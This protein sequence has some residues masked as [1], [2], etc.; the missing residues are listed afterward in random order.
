M[1][2]Q[3]L[4]LLVELY[5]PYILPMR[6][7]GK[8]PPLAMSMARLRKEMRSGCSYTSPFLRSPAYFLLMALTTESK[9]CGSTGDI[10]F[11]DFVFVCVLLEELLDRHHV[12][13]GERVEVVPDVLVP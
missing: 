11:L 3:P 9:F 10:W 6:P 4:R 12:V 2:F 8:P 5:G 1:R 7:I 13:D